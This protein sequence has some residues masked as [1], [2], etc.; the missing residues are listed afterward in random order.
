[1]PTETNEVEI[2]S[3]RIE[4]SGSGEELCLERVF[5]RYGWLEFR[6]ALCEF[7]ESEKREMR[8]ACEAEYQR[9]Q[10]LH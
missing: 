8:G 10:R 5:I 4:F 2:G 3:L 7:G 6:H 1:M 9:L